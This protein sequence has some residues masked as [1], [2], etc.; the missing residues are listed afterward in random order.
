VAQ[1]HVH[2]RPRRPQ[3]FHPAAQDVGLKHC[4]LT[5][6]SNFLSGLLEKDAIVLHCDER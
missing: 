3:G 2:G 6:S 1:C 4:Q 5:L